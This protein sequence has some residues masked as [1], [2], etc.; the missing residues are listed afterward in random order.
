MDKQLITNECLDYINW[1]H[2]HMMKDRAERAAKLEQV[3]KG[4]SP[5]ESIKKQQ[6]ALDRWFCESLIQSVEQKSLYSDDMF[7]GT[8]FCTESPCPVE[9]Q[10]VVD[11][12]KNACST[13]YT[14]KVNSR[15]ARLKRVLKKFFYARH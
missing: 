12:L 13:N 7:F 11:M 6:E 8:H 1:C 5:I 14:G 10:E 9:E 4:K 15:F 3:F 2:T